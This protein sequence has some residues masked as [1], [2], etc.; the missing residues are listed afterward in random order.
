VQ[1]V[2]YTAAG[3]YHFHSAA[4]EHNCSHCCCK[5]YLSLRPSP[6]LHGRL[7]ASPRKILSEILSAT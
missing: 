7:Y 1:Q 5:H 2:V 4:E 6:L 3:I